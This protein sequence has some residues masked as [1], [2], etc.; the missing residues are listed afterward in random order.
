MAITGIHGLWDDFTGAY[1]STVNWVES[2]AEAAGTAISRKVA[3]VTGWL[4]DADSNIAQGKAILD[5]LT[6]AKLATSQDKDMYNNINA[7]QADLV[8]QLQ[9]EVQAQITPAMQAAAPALSTTQSSEGQLLPLSGLGIIPAII[10]AG[11]VLT[12][13][14][15]LAYKIYHVYEDSNTYLQYMQARASAL[16]AGQPLPPL[17]PALQKY[18]GKSWVTW[19]LLGSLLTIGGGFLIYFKWIRKPVHNPIQH[20]RR[21]STIRQGEEVFR[22]FHHFH[23]TKVE[24]I[25]VPDG[26]P[27]TLVLIGSAHDGVIYGSD[28]FDHKKRSYI[29]KFSRGA[30][31]ATDVEGRGLYLIDDKMQVR[32]EG[33]VH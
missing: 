22:T 26:Y 19:V 29:H 20:Y 33:I 18:Q 17:P 27:K 23:P 10:A 21:N 30:Q 2:K 7:E 1:Y 4:T 32:P 5:Q 15:I 12:V 14:G 16:K 8:N 9:G 24:K 13:S 31:W 6:A 11:M 3:D 28:K 25:R